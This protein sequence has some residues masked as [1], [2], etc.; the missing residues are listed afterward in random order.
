M[1]PGTTWPWYLQHAERLRL[2]NSATWF[3]LKRR[4]SCAMVHWLMD[5]NAQTLRTMKLLGI[6]SEFFHISAELED[7][8]VFRQGLW[9]FEL[10]WVIP[11]TWHPICIFFDILSVWYSKI[12]LDP[13]LTKASGDKRV[14]FPPQFGISN[15]YISTYIYIYTYRVYIY[16]YT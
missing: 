11:A 7:W 12:Y 3:C 16:I 14:T 5:V 10:L 1:E 8:Y 2:D 4:R 15:Q 9:S 13:D 6:F